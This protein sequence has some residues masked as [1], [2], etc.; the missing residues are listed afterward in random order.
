MCSESAFFPF[1][2]VKTNTSSLCFFRKALHDGFLCPRQHKHPSQRCVRWCSIRPVVFYYSLCCFLTMSSD[3]GWGCSPACRRSMWQLQ[4]CCCV[5]TC[6]V[7]NKRT[8]SLKRSSSGT[9]SVFLKSSNRSTDVV[10]V[11]STITRVHHISVRGS[12]ALCRRWGSNI[13]LFPQLSHSGVFSWCL[14]RSPP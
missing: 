8:Q 11:V 9:T 12:L 6:V 4:L 2:S 14:T 7:N 1:P 5:V 13:W 3:R 10:V